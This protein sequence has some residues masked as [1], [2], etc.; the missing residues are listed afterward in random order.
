MSRVIQRIAAESDKN[1][2]DRV[3]FATVN[4]VELGIQSALCAPDQTGNI[5]GLSGL[6]SVRWA[7]KCSLL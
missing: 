3:T 1:R 2:S 7:F 5:P 6:A 4:R